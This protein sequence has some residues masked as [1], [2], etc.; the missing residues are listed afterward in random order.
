M[1]PEYVDYWLGLDPAAVVC[2]HKAGDEMAGPHGA[3][4]RYV[5]ALG[6]ERIHQK[7]RAITG[8]D[9]LACVRQC[10]THGL[11]MPDWLAFEFNRRYD[12][13][14]LNLR[15]ASWDD[16]L[17]FGRPVPKGAHVAAMRKRRTLRHQVANEVRRLLQESPD[18]K[19][20]EYLFE[21]A[22]LP[23]GIGKTLASEMYY[24]AQHHLAEGLIRLPPKRP[25]SRKYKKA[26]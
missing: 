25:T 15:A 11:V 9:V 20:D 2:L 17:A 3:M 5:A 4:F 14:A 22:G 26:G 23:F 6:I 16:P 1:S 18:N 13:V 19:I 24:E 12:A 8:V 7:G 10:A 21:R